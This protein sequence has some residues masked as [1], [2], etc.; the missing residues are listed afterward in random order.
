MATCNGA[1]ASLVGYEKW[2]FTAKQVDKITIL[3]TEYNE[4]KGKEY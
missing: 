3:I 1:W 4:H 2:V